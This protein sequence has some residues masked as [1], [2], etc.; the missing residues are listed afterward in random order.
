MIEADTVVN[1]KKM[2]TVSRDSMDGEDKYN[3]ANLGMQDDMDNENRRTKSGR[4]SNNSQT[5]NKNGSNGNNG[6]QVA[7]GDCLGMIVD[8]LSGSTVFKL[9]VDRGVVDSECCFMLDGLVEQGGRASQES[10]N[11]WL[12]EQGES[13]SQKLDSVTD[14][15]GFSL[16][17]DIMPCF[18]KLAVEGPHIVADAENRVSKKIKKWGPVQPLRKSNRIDRSKNVLEKAKECKMRSNLEIPPRK[19]K[20]IMESNPFNILQASVLN[21][22]ARE[23]GINIEEILDVDNIP[24]KVGHD[25]GLAAH[26]G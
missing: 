24:D 21:S 19:I 22:M 10:E 26:V 23:L 25:A 11:F 4:S 17:E 14:T 18:D 16:P 3:D 8:N 1:A 20:G 15:Q 2:D 9:L 7:G 6:K 13:F 5:S 12:E